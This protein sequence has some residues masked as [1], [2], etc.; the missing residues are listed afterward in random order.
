MPLLGIERQIVWQ[1]FNHFALTVLTTP[2]PLSS[3]VNQSLY[4]DSV[5][6][7]VPS[8][9]LNNVFFGGPGVTTGNGIELVAGA[10]PVEFRIANQFQQYDLLEPLLNVAAGVVCA[11][12]TP[13]AIPFAAWNLAEMN[14]IAAA[15][16]AV[17]VMT[18]QS[19]FV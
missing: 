4:Y 3:V 14:L 6:I 7:S 1:Q 19:M 11:P 9:A 2:T 15:N 13:K 18:F 8:A 16:T 12:Q 10:G 5:V 17:T